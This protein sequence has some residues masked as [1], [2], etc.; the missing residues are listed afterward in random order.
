LA[1]ASDSDRLAWKLG[2]CGHDDA[3]AAAALGLVEGVVGGGEEVIEGTAAWLGTATPIEMVTV[4]P[5][6]HG[7]ASR[8]VL[9]GG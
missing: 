7:H 3:V 9:A 2:V 8:R 5:R 1:G 4:L 6:C